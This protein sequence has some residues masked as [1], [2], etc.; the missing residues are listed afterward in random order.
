MDVHANAIGLTQS[1]PRLLVGYD[2]VDNAGYAPFSPMSLIAH[3]SVAVR[4]G[5]PEPE[6]LWVRR[7][8]AVVIPGVPSTE[9][10]SKL[11]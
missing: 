10:G 6:Y 8:E 1:S 11:S 2:A 7:H 5:T 4:T 9:S 3:A